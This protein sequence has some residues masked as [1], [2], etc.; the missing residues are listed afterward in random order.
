VKMVVCGDGSEG[1][2]ELAF[3]R[4]VQSDPDLVSNKP[5]AV[6]SMQVD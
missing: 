6:T 1:E 2:R 3:V 5:L 4:K